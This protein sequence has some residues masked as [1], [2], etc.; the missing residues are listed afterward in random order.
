MN[1]KREGTPT[2]KVRIKD[3]L[4]DDRYVMDKDIGVLCLHG[5]FGDKDV[6]HPSLISKSA[7]YSLGKWVRFTPI[8]EIVYRTIYYAVADSI[9]N[10]GPHYSNMSQTEIARFSSGINRYVAGCS[11]M[12]LA[13]AGLIYDTKDSSNAKFS[14]KYIPFNKVPVTGEVTWDD[15]NCYHLTRSWIIDKKVFSE[16]KHPVF[17]YREEKVVCLR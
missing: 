14:K 17:V 12:T 11:M 5:G 1:K 10:G 4:C 2:R 7:F 3:P 9:A 13:A 6:I 15:P 16:T 8:D